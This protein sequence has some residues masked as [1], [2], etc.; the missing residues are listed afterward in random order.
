MNNEELKSL[1]NKLGLYASEI[2]N[3]CLADVLRPW[4]CVKSHWHDESTLLLRFESN[5]LLMWS[6]DE[7]ICHDLNAVD[8]RSFQSSLARKIGADELETCLAWRSDEDGYRLTG[9]TFSELIGQ[10]PT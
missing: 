8:T 4:D 1:S 10:I 7:G 3:D 9:L 2:C 5:D 6:G